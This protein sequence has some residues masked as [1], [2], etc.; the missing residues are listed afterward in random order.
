M[1]VLI[2]LTGFR[3]HIEY[4]YWGILLKSCKNLSKYCDVFVHSNNISNNILDHV[5]WI[6]VPKQIYITEKNSGFVNGGLE[7]I[8]DTIDMLR[9]YSSECKYQYII[10][11]HPDVFICN[12]QP[13]LSL[14]EQEL[15][16]DNVFYCNLSLVN[17]CLYSFDFFI[18]KPKLLSENIFKNWKENNNSPE[19]YLYQCITKHNLKHVLLDRYDGDWYL[20]QR[21]SPDKLQLWHSHELELIIEC[22]N[23]EKS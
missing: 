15:N 8:S 14:L 7:A 17:P 3:Q 18:F 11:M 16:T 2:I 21:K 19:L 23:K 22:I 6:S 10:H 12:E 13:S 4:Q 5:Q 9:L 1:K 20:D